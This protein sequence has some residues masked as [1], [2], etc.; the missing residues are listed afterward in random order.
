MCVYQHFHQGML[1]TGQVAKWVLTPKTSA[2]MLLGK[3]PNN[4]S[5]GKYPR[6]ST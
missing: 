3:L 5:K 2:T 4:K 1:K 6:G